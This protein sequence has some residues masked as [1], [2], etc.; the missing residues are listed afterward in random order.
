VGDEQERAF[1]VDESLDEHL[2]GVEIEMV[3][4]LVEHQKI[5]RIVEHARQDDARLLATGQDAAALVH[6]VA[7]ETEGSEERLDRTERSLRVRGLERLQHGLI[8]VQDLHRVLREV[9]HLDAA[10]E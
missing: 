5:R 9:A 10:T 3:G 6:V 2:F 4:R 8:G 1:E 7:R